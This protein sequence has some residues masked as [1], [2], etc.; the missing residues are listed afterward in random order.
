MEGHLFSGLL[1]KLDCWAIDHHREQVDLDYD[2]MDKKLERTLNKVKAGFEEQAQSSHV[3]KGFDNDAQ[4]HL[5]STI[6]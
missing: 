3:V 4:E 6:Q 1:M 2:E 5:T